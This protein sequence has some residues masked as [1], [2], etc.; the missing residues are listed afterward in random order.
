M[1]PFAEKDNSLQLGKAI[2]MQM[3][4]AERAIK[5]RLPEMLRKYEPRWIAV[6]LAKECDDYTAELEADLRFIQMMPIVPP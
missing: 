6:E 3:W 2:F 4:L 5:A 1:V